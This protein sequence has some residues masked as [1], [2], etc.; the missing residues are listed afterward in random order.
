MALPAAAAAVFNGLQQNNNKRLL[1]CAGQNVSATARRAMLDLLPSLSA[2]RRVRVSPAPLHLR[3]PLLHRA[4]RTARLSQA[5]PAPSIPAQGARIAQ[6]LLLLGC[7]R[8]PTTN[9]AAAERLERG[10]TVFFPALSLLRSDSF[11]VPAPHHPRFCTP[12]GTVLSSAPWQAGGSSPW[13]PGR[14]WGAEPT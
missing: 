2:P 9:P 1:F 7:H 5:L 12:A 13:K 8:C 11:I 14:V 6:G 3:P 4:S 10:L